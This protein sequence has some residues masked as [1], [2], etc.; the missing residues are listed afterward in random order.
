M[1]QPTSHREVGVARNT[2]QARFDRLV[3]AGVITGFGPD[4]ELRR[5]GCTVSPFVSLEIAQGHR[6]SWRSW[7]PSPRSW[8]PT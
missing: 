2:A 1:H 3:R 8:R 5:V 6:P 4:L 7:P